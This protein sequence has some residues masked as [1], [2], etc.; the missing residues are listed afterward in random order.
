[1]PPLRERREDIPVLA[2]I[3]FHVMLH[4]T[5]APVRGLRPSGLAV[6]DAIRLAGQCARAGTYAGA[7]RPD[8][9]HRANPGCRPG[10]SLQRPQA[11]NLEELSLEAVES[12]PDPEGAAALPGK[13]EPGGRGARSKPRRALSP[14]G[15]VWALARVTLKGSNAK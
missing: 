4:A 15:K 10:L 1:M 2:A 13:C 11:Q 14:D 9:P 3:F 5:A 6:V 12:Y 8:V 7:G